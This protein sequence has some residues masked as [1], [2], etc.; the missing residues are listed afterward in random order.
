MDEIHNILKK[1][2]EEYI[3]GKL[4]A[5]DELIPFAGSSYKDTAEIYDC[6]T[7][8]KHIDRNPKGLSLRDACCMTISSWL[9]CQPLDSSHYSLSE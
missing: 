2:D 6:I 1:Y 3:T 9:M 7:R 4:K 5:L 8:V